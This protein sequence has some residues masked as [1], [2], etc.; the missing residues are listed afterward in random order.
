MKKLAIIIFLL[1]AISIVWFAPRRN[2]T[3][4]VGTAK[5]NIIVADSP[6]EI[7]QGLSDQASMGADDGML[8]ILQ[9][10]T[11]PR[12]WMK[13]MHFGLDIIW[14]DEEKKIV[15]IEKNISPDTYPATFTPPTLIKYVIEVNAGWA[16]AHGIVPGNLVSW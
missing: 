14:I 16:D 11:I 7:V 13:D 5:L 12:F 4:A 1:I 6:A 2:T 8:F 3:I 10:S 9:E 15:G